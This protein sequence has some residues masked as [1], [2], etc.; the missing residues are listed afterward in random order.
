MDKSNF[1]MTTDDEINLAAS[2]QYLLTFPI[3]VDESKVCSRVDVSRLTLLIA[4]CLREH[5]CHV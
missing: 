2:A 1:K 5:E 4:A 3:K